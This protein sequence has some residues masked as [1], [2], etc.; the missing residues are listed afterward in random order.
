MWLMQDLIGL[1]RG[2]RFCTT[3]RS[4]LDLKFWQK[5]SLFLILVGGTE[6]PGSPAPSERRNV[7]F[8]SN[9]D[10]RRKKEMNNYLVSLPTR[11]LEK[12]ASHRYEFQ[13]AISEP[14]TPAASSHYISHLAGSTLKHREFAFMTMLLLIVITVAMT[15]IMMV[16]TSSIFP[17]NRP[18]GFAWVENPNENTLE[19]PNKGAVWSVGILCGDR[20]KTKTPEHPVL[21]AFCS[22]AWIMVREWI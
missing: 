2:V 12:M 5:Y 19:F 11:W 21:I 16:T 15:M 13:I 7:I 14:P 10:F 8:C 3:L 22:S 18:Q 4:R 17:A 20:G 6:E 9:D 1:L